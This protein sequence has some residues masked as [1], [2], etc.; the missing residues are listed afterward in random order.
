MQ[1]L[2]ALGTSL[3]EAEK[4]AKQQAEAVASLQAMEQRLQNQSVSA[5]HYP[6]H[7]KP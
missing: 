5:D 4:Q 1:S 2:Q 7:W 3:E 6:S